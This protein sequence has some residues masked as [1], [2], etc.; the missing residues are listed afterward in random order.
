MSDEPTAD[1]NLISYQQ[2]TLLSEIGAMRE[3]LRVM[4]ATLQR[5]DGTVVGLVEEVRAGRS[6]P[7]RS[8]AARLGGARQPSPPRAPCPC[9]FADGSAT[10]KRSG[11]IPSPTF[12]WRRQR[13]QQGL[14]QA[15]EL[16]PA[17]DHGSA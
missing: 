3:E 2:A 5:L 1:M 17:V 15:A 7:V 16:W 10:R 9:P 12:P 14:P 8:I 4:S 11:L 13:S 6:S